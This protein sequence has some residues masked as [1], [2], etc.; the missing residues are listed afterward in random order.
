MNNCGYVLTIPSCAE[1]KESMPWFMQ[2]LG[3]IVVAGLKAA[4][5]LLLSALGLAGVAYYGGKDKLKTAGDWALALLGFL[6]FIF[7]LRR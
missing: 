2:A 5:P 4:W 3:D 1:G 7:T 6:F